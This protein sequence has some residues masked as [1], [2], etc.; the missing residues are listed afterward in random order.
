MEIFLRG[1]CRG[2]GH[3]GDD[4]GASWLRTVGCGVKSMQT[5]SKVITRITIY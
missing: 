2:S 5:I 4:D 3:V 1:V